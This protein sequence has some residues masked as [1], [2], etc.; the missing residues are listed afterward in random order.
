LHPVGPGYRRESDKEKH[1]VRVGFLSY[2][3]LNMHRGGLPIRV[4]STLDALRCHG[5]DCDFVNPFTESLASYDLIHVFGAFHSNHLLVRAARNADRPVVLSSVLFPDV[6]RWD[7]MV[8]NFVDRLFGRL[9]H[10]EWQ[11]TYRQ[12]R[13]ALNEAD[14]IIVLGNA[15]RDLVHDVYAGDLAKVRIIPNAV[16]QPF[17]DAKPDSF[18]KRFAIT[19]PFVLCAA[20]L[21]DMK[22]QLT[23]VHAL[24]GLD[25]D[26]VLV[27]SVEKYGQ[28]YLDRCLADGGERVRYIGYID[29]EDPLLPSAFAAA[30]VF[31]LP[32]KAEVSPT[33]ALEA[34][35]TGTPT[36]L[37][38]YHSLDIRP[39][40]RAFIECDPYRERDIRNA[41]ARAL[42]AHAPAEECRRLVADCLWEDVVQRTTAVY[43]ECLREAE[44]RRR[45]APSP[46]AC[47]K[48]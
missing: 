23:L 37:T 34:L 21:G 12:I 40:G 32:S 35:A 24:K 39:D 48:A 4:R 3:V 45:G 33:A 44:T 41:V 11:T 13:I 43:D 42:A 16:A 8:A 46:G 30:E 10:W 7:G 1:P 15:E 38:K 9:T 47:G 36:V 25:I 28:A 22:N 14:R 20:F 29:H 31:V 18:R 17:F 6:S 26:L 27:G 2:L 19:R 5:I